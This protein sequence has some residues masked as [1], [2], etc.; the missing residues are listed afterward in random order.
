[1]FIIICILIFIIFFILGVISKFLIKPTWAK[2]FEVEFSDEIGTLHSDLPYGDK[3]ANK[4]DIYLPKDDQKQNYGLVVYLHAGGFTSGDK[5]DDK[6]MLEWLCSKGYVAV[7]I[8]YTLFNENNPQANVYTQSIEI[9]QAMPEIVSKAGEYGY[10][11]NQMAIGGGSAGHALAMIYAY[12]YAKEAPVPIKLLFGAVGPSSFYA[13]DWDIYGFDQDTAEARTS[14]AHLFGVM[15]GVELTPQ[16]IEDKSY[17]DKLKPISAE[18]WI[19][20]Q[21]VPSVVAYGTYDKMQPFKASK[22]LLSAYQ[23]N[24]VDYQ[25]FECSHS[26]HG[27]QNDN[28]VYGNYMKT[29]EV[30]LNKYLPV[31]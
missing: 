1:M 13:E 7:G 3:P 9:K 19:D 15:G 6:K 8:N 28:E 2:D 17:L 27:L 14:A 25:Y 12:E 30:Y 10:H 5:T 20:E 23:K 21:T 24:N 11:I 26:G 4:F 29:V 16:M 22:R 18:M 31:E